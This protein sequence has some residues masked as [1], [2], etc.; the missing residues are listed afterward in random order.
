MKKKIKKKE[1]RPYSMN[2]N[3][4]DFLVFSYISS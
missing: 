3:A 2:E 4:S 1:F